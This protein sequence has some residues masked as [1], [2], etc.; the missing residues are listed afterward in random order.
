MPKKNKAKS[1]KKHAKRRF[2][3]R[4]GLLI[5]ENDLNHIRNKIQEGDG[6]LVEKQSN[7]VSKWRVPFKDSIFTV[8]YDKMRKTI[9]TVL[10]NEE[11]DEKTT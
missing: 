9:V 7:R 2:Y 5:E 3:E 8:I 4:F 10:P 6:E 11:N 1:Q